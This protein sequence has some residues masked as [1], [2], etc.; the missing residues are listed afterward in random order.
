MGLVDRIFHNAN[1]A[2]W[3]GIEL[4]AFGFGWCETQLKVSPVLFQQH[5]FV[6]GGVLMTLADHTCGGAKCRADVLR[7]G[8]SLI[9]VE[10]AVTG[11]RNGHSML[12]AKASSTLAA[13]A[14]KASPLTLQSK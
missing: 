14:A 5:E 12:V 7:S 3:M 8:T 6:H 4:L 1:F 13:I 2:R 11:E 9:F 10:A